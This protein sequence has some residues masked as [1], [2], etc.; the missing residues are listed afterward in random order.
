MEVSLGSVSQNVLYE[1]TNWIMNK[2]LQKM[3]VSLLIV[4]VI[5]APL[6]V[7]ILIG[8]CV[9]LTSVF[10]SAVPHIDPVSDLDVLIYRGAGSFHDFMRRRSCAPDPFLEQAALVVLYRQNLKV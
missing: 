8:S 9:L 6:E 7:S 3:A 10:Y 5:F 2:K 4:T 1:D